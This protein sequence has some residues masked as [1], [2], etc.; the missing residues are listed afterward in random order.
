MR[1]RLRTL[2]IATTIGPPLLAAAIWFV[3]IGGENP[4]LF[5]AG[6]YIGLV[7]V[8]ILASSLIEATNGAPARWFPGNVAAAV[9]RFFGRRHPT[10][11]CS[12]CGLAKRPLAEGMRGVLICRECAVACTELIDKE[13]RAKMESRWSDERL[14]D[15]LVKKQADSPESTI[16]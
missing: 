6:A 8:F 13:R 16:T 15:P 9:A 4:T 3:G 11:T 14:S 1:Y 12:F 5:F 7:V 2:L 10:G